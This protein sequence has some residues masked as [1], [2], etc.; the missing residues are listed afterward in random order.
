[1]EPAASGNFHE[2]ISH[3]TSFEVDQQNGVSASVGALLCYI[4]QHKNTISAGHG[5]QIIIF[6]NLCPLV[7]KVGNGISV[8][9][10]LGVPA[11]FG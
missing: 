6:N 11:D 4:L 8:C 5:S 1:M 9:A 7:M 2:S 3:V 10:R